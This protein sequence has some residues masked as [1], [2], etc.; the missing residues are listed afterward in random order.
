[1]KGEKR[2]VNLCRVRLQPSRLLAYQDIAMAHA[3][4]VTK[5]IET[6]MDVLIADVQRN[7][8]GVAF[9]ALCVKH[10]AL[11]LDAVYAGYVDDLKRKRK[12]K[13]S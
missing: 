6:V 4:T 10:G 1:M 5:L 9:D 12:G 11:D 2:T 7:E 8:V 13:K 3:V